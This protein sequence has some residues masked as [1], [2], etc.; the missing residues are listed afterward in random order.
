[1]AVTLRA[2]LAAGKKRAQASRDLHDAGVVL[3][4]AE[5]E[6]PACGRLRVSC[7]S[8]LA[9][10]KFFRWEGA[11]QEIS[12]S[13]GQPATAACSPRMNCCVSRTCWIASSGSY[14]GRS[15]DQQQTGRIPAFG[16]PG[17]CLSSTF[18]RSLWRLLRGKFEGKEL[19][20]FVN[21]YIVVTLRDLAAPGL[22]ATSP[23]IC[24]ITRAQRVCVQ[25]S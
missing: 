18:H 11:A 12:V 6:T 10:V 16:A 4:S 22:P 14:R 24:L 19:K 8:I 21:R 20:R 1:V 23:P 7:R 3:D 9:W 15:A 25:T 13:E 5:E 2:D 17:G